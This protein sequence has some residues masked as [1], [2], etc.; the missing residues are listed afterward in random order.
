[1]LAAPPLAPG[2]AC[3]GGEPAATIRRI[4]DS[5]A[6]NR[7]ANLRVG[8]SVRGATVNLPRRAFLDLAVAIAALAAP[9]VYGKRPGLSVAACHHRSA[10]SSSRPVSTAD[11]FYN[12]QS[13][14]HTH[15]PAVQDNVARFGSDRLQV[16]SGEQ[17]KES[18]VIYPIHGLQKVADEFRFHSRMVGAAVSP[19]SETAK[20]ATSAS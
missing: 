11:L 18:F 20:P 6:R 19:H 3:G 4:T 7:A 17:A 1:M 12:Q 13:C 14:F 16:V 9:C 5:R 2:P 15:D 10:V 8:T